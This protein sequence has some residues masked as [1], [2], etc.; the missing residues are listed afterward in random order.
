MLA[1]TEIALEIWTQVMMLLAWK[2]S[3]PI[4][5]HPLD[6]VVHVIKIE[7]IF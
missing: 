2:L 3:L 4:A 5:R 7:A 1:H 6:D